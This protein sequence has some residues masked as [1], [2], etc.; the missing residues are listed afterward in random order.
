MN[1]KNI[2]NKIKNFVNPKKYIVNKDDGVFKYIVVGQKNGIPA[3]R[4]VIV[5][6]VSMM[7]DNMTNPGI[8]VVD[9]NKNV[10]DVIM[11]RYG[12]QWQFV[13]PEADVTI[14]PTAR[15]KYR[16]RN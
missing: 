14:Y 4:W 11:T 1:I 16:E 5:E 10:I 12:I 6:R 13:M 7:P 15:R 2:I 3:G 9:A 8:K